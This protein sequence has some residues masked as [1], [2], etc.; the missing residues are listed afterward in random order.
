MPFDEGDI[1]DQ[2]ALIFVET[3]QGRQRT[4]V[5]MKVRPEAEEKLLTVLR[6]SGID[7]TTVRVGD[8]LPEDVFSGRHP[9]R[10]EDRQSPCFGRQ[11][12]PGDAQ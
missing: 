6:K 1:E 9:R 10:G 8:P 11:V 5:K 12:Q 3:F 2:N 7:T 4:V